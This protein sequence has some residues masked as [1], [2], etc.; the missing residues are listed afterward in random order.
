MLDDPK[1]PARVRAAQEVSRQS[2]FE[3]ACEDRAGALLRT[4]A[5]T[6]PGG[7]LLELGT[8][9]GVGTAWML[10]GM[11][12][13]ARL[14]T[15]D[16]DKEVSDLARRTVDGDPRVELVV[17]EA[18]PWLEEYA[19]PPFDLVFVDTWRGKFIDR[20]RLLRRLAP[21]GIYFGDD[22]LPQPT[23]ADQQPSLVGTFLDE[24]VE[25]TDLA[26][27]I[28]NWSSGLVLAAKRH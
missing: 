15:I 13:G 19:G 7:N 9:T 5:A 24:I 12:T 10:A 27:T 16:R 6:K 21:G 3:M 20:G 26:V 8:G 4:L 17:G 1:L 14:V 23:W 2:G 22:L 25:D 18:G 28:M 11:D